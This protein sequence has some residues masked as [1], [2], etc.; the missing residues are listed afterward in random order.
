MVQIRRDWMTYGR[1]L[2]NGTTDADR[3]QDH[4]SD[5]ES[6]LNIGTYSYLTERTRNSN[7]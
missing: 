2:V 5:I 3:A 1:W 6:Q 7:N 4:W